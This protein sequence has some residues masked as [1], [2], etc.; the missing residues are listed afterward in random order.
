M[1][2]EITCLGCGKVLHVPDSAAGKKGKCPQCGAILQ[3]PVVKV[4]PFT[5]DALEF[6]PPSA[7]PALPNNRNPGQPAFSASDAKRKGSRAIGCGWIS[8]IACI[9]LGMATLMV[10]YASWSNAQ[11]SPHYFRLMDFSGFCFSVGALLI[12]VGVVT[13][14]VT[15]SCYVLKRTAQAEAPPVPGL[16]FASL[17]LGILSCTCCLNLL[18][19]PSILAIAFGTISL[20][21]VREGTSGGEKQARIGRTCGIVGLVVTLA[22]LVIGLVLHFL[23]H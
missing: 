1:A 5:E 19:I 16:A 9:L 11:V 21:K 2:I 3:V 15:F 23:T 10:S 18:L 4:P 12:I 17:I 13:A 22:L 20:R 14:F 7:V 8:A 6:Q